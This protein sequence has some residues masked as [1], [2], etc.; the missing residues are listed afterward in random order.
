[1]PFLAL[2]G[3]TVQVALNA[4][5]GDAAPV[6]KV[7][8]SF[9]GTARSSVRSYKDSWSLTT[10]WLTDTEGDTLEGILEGA[11]PL[12]ATGDLTGPVSVVVDGPIAR[13]YAKFA[14][15]ERRRLTFTLLEV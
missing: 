11:P 6:G 2:G 3:T 13:E 14:D 4:N 7:E 15:G 8:R 12:A 1:M 9:D 5:S 10:R